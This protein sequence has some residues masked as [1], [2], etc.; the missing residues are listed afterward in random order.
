MKKVILFFLLISAGLLSCNDILEPEAD[1]FVNASTFYDTE[2]SIELAVNGAYSQLQDLYYTGSSDFWAIT[3][4]RSDNTTF[5]YNHGNRG[6]HETEF[7]DSFLILDENGPIEE[8]WSTIYTGISQCN[9]VLNRIENVEFS[10]STLK[11]QYT[12][13]LKFIRAVHYFHLVRLFG[14][15][16]LVLDEVESPDDA[17]SEGRASASEVYQQI[18]ND[19]NDATSSLPENYSGADVGRAT[20]GAAYTL[21]ADVY[22]TQEDYSAASDALEQVINMNYS[23]LTDYSDVFDPANKNNAESIFEIQ[24]S[25]SIE[26]EASEFAYRFVPFNSGSDI[27]GFTDLNPSHAGYNIPTRDVI[28]AYEQGDTRKDASIAYYVNP[29]NSQYDVA[30]G[31][32]IPYIKKF[33]HSFEQ[34]GRTNENVPVYRYAHVLLMMAEVINEVEGPTSE[35]YGYINQVRQRAGLNNLTPGLSKEE[36]RDAVYHEQRVE[37]AF[38]NHRW[39]DLLRT[40]RAIEVMNAHGEEQKQLVPRLTEETYNVVEYKLLLPIPLREVRLNNLEQNPGW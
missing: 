40:N 37:L 18:I 1:S 6:E 32:S 28:R 39:Y 27:I 17:F 19:V 13:E 26:G 30:I 7:L 24:F 9:V 4:M 20:K 10:N 36:F 25:S 8:V 33:V 15:V 14:G 22:L 5:Q 2:E 34:P 21:L 16:P 12:G 3:E 23:L 31:D 11:E 38:E 29:E 35:A